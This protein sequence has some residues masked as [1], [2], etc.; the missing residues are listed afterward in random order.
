MALVPE[1]VAGLV[2]LLKGVHSRQHSWLAESKAQQVVRR[3]CTQ[4]LLWRTQQIRRL[5]ELRRWPQ[6]GH[7]KGA[8][9]MNF[10]QL[11]R[12]LRPRRRE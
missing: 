3:L 6:G 10:S 9:L 4:E 12:R 5:G 11:N 8:T 1:Y 7:N 2:E